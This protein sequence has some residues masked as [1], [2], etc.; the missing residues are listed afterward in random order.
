MRLSG[1]YRYYGF[2]QICINGKWRGI[3]RDYNHDITKVICRQLGYS[4]VDYTTTGSYWV[5]IW[6][7]WINNFLLIALYW[8]SDN[9]YFYHFYKRDL[10]I[11]MG[12]EMAL[13]TCFGTEA[14]LTE[15]NYYDNWNYWWWW[16]KGLRELEFVT[17]QGIH[18]INCSFTIFIIVCRW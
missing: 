10:Y 17:C 11:P 15:C 14:N 8:E 5:K 9:F 18:K 4:Y 6:N 16:W 7:W 12:S 1:G 2:A 13:F 3:H